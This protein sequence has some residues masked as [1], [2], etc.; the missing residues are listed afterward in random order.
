MRI[1]STLS[2]VLKFTGH[3]NRSFQ[4]TDLLVTKTCGFSWRTEYVQ[5]INRSVI[6]QFFAFEAVLKL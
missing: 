3:L 2:I 6:F 5:H 1:P 4:M